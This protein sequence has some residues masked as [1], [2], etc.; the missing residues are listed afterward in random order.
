MRVFLALAAVAAVIA[1][2]CADEEPKFYGIYD[3]IR[4]TLG[5]SKI[6]TFVKIG[7]IYRIMMIALNNLGSK[8]HSGY[9]QD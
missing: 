1:S 5:V 7:P 2:T 4:R 9:N 8:T 6:T 3:F